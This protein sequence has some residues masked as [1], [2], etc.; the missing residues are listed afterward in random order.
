[1]EMIDDFFIKIL[2]LSKKRDILEACVTLSSLFAG[3]LA[4]LLCWM[5]EQ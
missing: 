3:S 2:Y 1:M 4:H 5:Y